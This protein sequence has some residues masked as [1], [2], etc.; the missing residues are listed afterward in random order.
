M[1]LRMSSRLRRL[2]GMTRSLSPCSQCGGRGHVVVSELNEHDAVPQPP[3]CAECG[4][5]MHVVMRYVSKPI[6]YLNSKDNEP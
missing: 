3:G 1:M 5:V 4:E 6:G 2:E